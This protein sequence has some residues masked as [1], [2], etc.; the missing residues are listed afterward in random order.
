MTIR[1]TANF[2]F[3]PSL[4][5]KEDIISHLSDLYPSTNPNILFRPYDMGTD[6]YYYNQ[7]VGGL[8]TDTIEFLNVTF[9]IKTNATTVSQIASDL[10][11]LTNV[12]GTSKVQVNTY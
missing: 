12:I 11:A 4:V 6:P 1:V 2:F 8:P 9:I 7:F 3:K 5:T 10:T